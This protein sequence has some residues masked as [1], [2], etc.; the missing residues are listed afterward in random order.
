[1]AETVM[2]NVNLST[3][4]IHAVLLDSKFQG[5]TPYTNAATWDSEVRIDPFHKYGNYEKKVRRIDSWL[6]VYSLRKPISNY[7]METL[8]DPAKIAWT[9][10]HGGN[11]GSNK[12]QTP[13]YKLRVHFSG[14]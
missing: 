9:T 7:D 14:E 6:L 5:S 4:S 13:L 8:S 3:P 2:M 12:G 11:L 10:F 1:M